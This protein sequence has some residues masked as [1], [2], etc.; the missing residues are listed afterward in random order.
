MA[1]D[2]EEGRGMEGNIE[3]DNEADDEVE[4]GE[5]KVDREWRDEALLL[6]SSG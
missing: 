5:G 4:G 1:E 6:E 3:D 2:E